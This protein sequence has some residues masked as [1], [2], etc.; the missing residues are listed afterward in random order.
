MLEQRE[1]EG[2]RQRDDRAQVVPR[3]EHRDGE[4][5]EGRERGRHDTPGATA[6]E[7]EREH[8]E[9]QRRQRREIAAEQVL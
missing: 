8:A 9:E 4:H 6:G 7:P 3:R 5:R 1:V 2:V